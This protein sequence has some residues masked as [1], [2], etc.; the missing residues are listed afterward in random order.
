MY[1]FIFDRVEI[2]KQ[3]VSEFAR[4]LSAV[5]PIMK[6][7]TPRSS[8]VSCT[9]DAPILARDLVEAIL[10]EGRLTGMS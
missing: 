3:G 1:R 2:S 7:T 9:N 6:H 8:T 5:A 4:V 10:G